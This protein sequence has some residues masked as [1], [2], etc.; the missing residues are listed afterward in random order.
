[1][2]EEIFGP[3]LPLIEYEKLDDAINDIR[4]R[5]KPLALYLFSSDKSVWRRIEKTVSFGG[6]CINDCL[7]HVSSPYLPFGGVGDSGMGHYHGKASFNTFSHYKSIV[8]KSTKMDF[9]VRYR[10]YDG[11][12]IKMIH[13]L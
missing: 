7:L 2:Q 13:K 11:K 1:M 3:L 10:P 8:N 4:R 5:P 6:G 12:K 9:D